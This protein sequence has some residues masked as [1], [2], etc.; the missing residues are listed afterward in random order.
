MC[1]GS[2]RDICQQ[3]TLFNHLKYKVFK[4]MAKSKMKL[5]PPMYKNIIRLK[6]MSYFF[7]SHNEYLVSRPNQIYFLD[8]LHGMYGCFCAQIC[9]LTSGRYILIP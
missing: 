2:P 7:N 8:P 9:R 6:E 4:K 1:S 3:S 5:R